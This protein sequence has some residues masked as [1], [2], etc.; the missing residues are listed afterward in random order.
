MT[1]P[2]PD[3][4]R[5]IDALVAECP[6]RDAPRRLTDPEDRR[7]LEALV[8][9]GELIIFGSGLSHDHPTARRVF[10]EALRYIDVYS[11]EH[12][13]HVL[14]SRCRQLL[15]ETVHPEAARRA[16]EFISRCASVSD[17]GYPIDDARHSAKRECHRIVCRVGRAHPELV[18][19]ALIRWMEKPSAPAENRLDTLSLMGEIGTERSFACMRAFVARPEAEYYLCPSVAMPLWSPAFWWLERH[20]FAPHFVRALNDTVAAQRWRARLM[21]AYH[22]QLRQWASFFASRAGQNL[23]ER[24]APGGVQLWDYWMTYA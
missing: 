21:V 22:L 15:A 19:P 11:E 2:D 20:D 9:A 12:E 14:A 24:L 10:A 3:V 6:P 16:L 4:H 17:L 23:Y 8:R 13:T 5:L 1:A 7:E 18:E